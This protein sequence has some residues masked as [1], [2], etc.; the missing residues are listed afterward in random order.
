MQDPTRRGSSLYCEQR[1]S[2]VAKNVASP[3]LDESSG[4]AATSGRIQIFSLEICRAWTT[5]R[6]WA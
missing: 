2:S 6:T 1:F 4:E 3:S 5:Q